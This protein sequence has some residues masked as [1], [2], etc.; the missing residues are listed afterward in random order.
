[1]GETISEA[2]KDPFDTPEANACVIKDR[3]R[4]ERGSENG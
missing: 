3:G 1:M 4:R 2:R